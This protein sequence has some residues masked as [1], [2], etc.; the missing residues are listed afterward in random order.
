MALMNQ[1]IQAF[2]DTAND[3]NPIRKNIAVHLRLKFSFFAKAV[4]Q[5]GGILFKSC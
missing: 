5:S 2:I 3:V 4:T 1:E